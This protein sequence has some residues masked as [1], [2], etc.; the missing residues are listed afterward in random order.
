MLVKE[1]IRE[2]YAKAIITIH[3]TTV[4]MATMTTQEKGKDR[5][6]YENLC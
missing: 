5:K 3:D 6:N 4:H 2:V 1:V